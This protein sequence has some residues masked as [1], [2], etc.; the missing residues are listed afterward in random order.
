MF[1]GGRVVDL[2]GGHG[3][4]AQAM[5]LLDD[6]SPA[7]LVV[8]RILPASAGKVHASLVAAWPR[9]DGR[10]TFVSAGIEDVPLDASDVVVSSHACGA[11][12]DVVLER[13]TAAR[14]R[15]AVLPCCHDL[16][17][18]DAGALAGWVDGPLAVDVMRAV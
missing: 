12:S 5:L 3:L 18:C 17:V 4:L 16:G 14:A 1:R 2:C 11:L 13:A 8:D 9:L 7:G 15:V 6:S 10:I